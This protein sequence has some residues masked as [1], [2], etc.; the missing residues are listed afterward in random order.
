MPAYDGSRFAPPAPVAS[1]VVRH[2][3]SG[4]SVSDVPMLIDSGAD[5][6]LTP[7]AIVAAIGGTAANQRYQLVGFDGTTSEADA[8]QAIVVFLNKRFRG[9]Y[10]V[11]DTEIGILGRDVLNHLRLTLDGPKLVWE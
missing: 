4:V 7:K 2:P 6:T 8:V 11:I 10:L 5:V 1:V 9:Q 3:D